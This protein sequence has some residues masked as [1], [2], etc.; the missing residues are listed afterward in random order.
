MGT[1]MAAKALP[2]GYTL[3]IGTASAMVV[4]PH[5]SPVPYDPLHDLA[6]IVLATTIPLIIVVHPSVP[7]R[8]VRELIA[9]AKAQPGQRL[10]MVRP[11]MA[12]SAI[13]PA[14]CLKS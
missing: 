4:S 5:M 13:S 3:L 8:S 14:S 2:D 1:D 11:A 10:T 7:V 12:P 9:L 6:P